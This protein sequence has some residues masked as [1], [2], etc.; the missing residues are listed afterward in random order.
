[1]SANEILGYP[2]D[3]RLLIVNA[4][5]FGMC[6]GQNIGTIR[7]MKQGLV[8]SCSLMVPAPWSLHAMRY[9]QANPQVPFGVHL[10]VVSEFVHYRW[11]PLTP[12]EQVPTLVDEFGYFLPDD[13][14]DDLLRQAD[15]G[16]LEQEFRAQIAVVLSSGLTPSHLDSHYHIHEGRRDICDLTVGLALEY[17]LALRIGSPANIERLQGMGYPTNDHPVLDSGRIDPGDKAAALAEQ[18]RELPPGLSEW[19]IHP[20]V[21]TEELR[22]VM[23]DPRIEGVTATPEGR[24]SDYDFVVSDEARIIVEEEDIRVVDYRG[25]QRCWQA[26]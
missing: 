11:G 10:T 5:D 20:G 1:V 9:L 18:L 8:S 19:G 21:S 4:D 25:L 26:S 23:K 17:G 22:A 15:V 24:Q 12:P 2:A 7:S 14:F 13:R 6:H 16:E 3:A